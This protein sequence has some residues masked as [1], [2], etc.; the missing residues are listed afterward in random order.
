MGSDNY[1]QDFTLSLMENDQ[2]AL[3]AVAEALERINDG[4]YGKCTECG[5]TIPKTRLD[6]LPHTPVCINCATL[7]EQG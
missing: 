1:E 2:Q 7:L 5:K 4:S 6:V 3:N